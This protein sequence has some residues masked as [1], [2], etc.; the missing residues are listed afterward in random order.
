MMRH[1]WSLF[2]RSNSIWVAWVQHYLLKGRSFWSVSI[3]QN[4]SWCWS[5]LLKM[6]SVAR[7]FLKFEVGDGKNI[8]LW[9][10]H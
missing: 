10:D 7:G 2:A 6:T 5:K 9:L 4:C 8:H 3:P 1:I